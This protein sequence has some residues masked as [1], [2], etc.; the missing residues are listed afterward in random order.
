MEGERAWGLSISR[1]HLYL[2]EWG[3]VAKE[4]FKEE[5]GGVHAESSVK[6]TEDSAV[7]D[8]PSKRNQ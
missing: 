8:I 4:M 5:G 7:G 1:T 6:F 3:N 2:S